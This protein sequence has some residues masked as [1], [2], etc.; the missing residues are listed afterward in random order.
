MT[1][2]KNV[3][4]AAFDLLSFSDIPVFHA[5]KMFPVVAHSAE[6]TALEVAV[7]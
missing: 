1:V 4:I 3:I 6:Y 2:L 5:K 7:S